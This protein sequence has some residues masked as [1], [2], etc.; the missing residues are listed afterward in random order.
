M[1]KKVFFLLVGLQGMVFAQAQD[2]AAQEVL[3]EVSTLQE[4]KKESM[5]QKIKKFNRVVKYLDG[6]RDCLRG[7]GCSKGQSYLANLAL[8][9]AIGFGN[10][11]VSSLLLSKQLG[12]RAEEFKETPREETVGGGLM[13]LDIIAADLGYRYLVKDKVQLF[14]CLTFR[15]CSEQTK[16]YAFFKLGSLPTFVTTVALMGKRYRTEEARKQAAGYESRWIWDEKSKKWK[17]EW[18]KPKHEAPGFDWSSYRQYSS[19]EPRPAGPVF[20]SVRIA[21]A[22]V[23]K[24]LGLKADGEYFQWYEVFGFDH[25]PGRDIARK[26]Y[27]RLSAQYHPDVTKL[28]DKKLAEEVFKAIANA[29]EYY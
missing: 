22:E 24:E 20:G 8:G 11:L 6:A 1:K 27:R 26:Q 9:V 10:G 23:K 18:R 29:G 16:R 3:K 4:P 5:A 2:Q 7:I 25:N 15:G 13:L 19:E 21:D 14:R 28:E 12:E 17:K